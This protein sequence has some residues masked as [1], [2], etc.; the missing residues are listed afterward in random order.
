MAYEGF[1]RPEL[2]DDEIAPSL[3][4]V[5]DMLELRAEEASA[6]AAYQPNIALLARTKNHVEGLRRIVNHV[7]RQREA[8]DGRIDICAV[9]TESTDGTV[10]L[11]EKADITLVSM[12]QDIFSYPLAMNVGLSV[13][14]RDVVATFITDGY[15]LPVLKNCLSGGVRHFRDEN[16]VGVFGH[17]VPHEN[18]S[19]SEKVGWQPL[20]CEPAYRLTTPEEWG[21]MSGSSCMV[22][23][24][25]WRNEHRFDEAYGAGGE[26][27]EWGTWAIEAG[28][29]IIR[30][31]VLAVHHSH[32]LDELHYKRHMEHYQTKGPRP[33]DQADIRARRPDLFQTP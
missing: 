3:Q 28:Y 7:R 18:A 25:T 26:D 1:E 14:K 8:Y 10:E 15:A 19:Y 24:Q 2:F 16:V 29:G 21:V 20:Y 27:G 9:D 11:A 13:V 22:R 17:S 33:F 4:V 23:M 32:G 6:D 5:R 12:G 30:D 31:P